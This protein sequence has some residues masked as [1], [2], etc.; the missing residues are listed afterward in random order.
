MDEW[1]SFWSLFKLISRIEGV[2]HGEDVFL[3]YWNDWR[4]F[5]YSEDEAKVGN[6]LIQLY[7]N[8]AENNKA[9]YDSLEIDQVKPN[10]FKGLEILSPENRKIVEFDDT[11]GNVAFW[12]AIVDQLEAKVVKDE[13]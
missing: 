12:N 5:P 4:E 1:S 10:H 6:G 9:I 8:F 7:Y 11:F 13:L 3:I 2:A